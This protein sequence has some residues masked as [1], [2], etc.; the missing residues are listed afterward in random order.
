[1]RRSPAWCEPGW[2]RP[3]A[4]QPGSR[5]PAAHRGRR[6]GREALTPV[7]ARE[8]VGELRLGPCRLGVDAA[9]AD[10]GAVA[11]ARDREPAAAAERMATGPQAHLREGERRIAR[12]AVA[13]I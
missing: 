10:H 3:S 12:L 6:F 1:M 5:G 11:T 4:R 2:R 8:G 7:R 9:P 13:E